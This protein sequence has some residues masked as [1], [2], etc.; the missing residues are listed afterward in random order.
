MMIIEDT[1]VPGTHLTTLPASRADTQ[2]PIPAPESMVVI[3]LQQ[4]PL[5]IR[6][7]IKKPLSK[8]RTRTL[9]NLVWIICFLLLV[10]AGCTVNSVVESEQI[11]TASAM[12]Q[13]ASLIPF[14]PELMGTWVADDPDYIEP[15]G[16][17]DWYRNIE[18][19]YWH[20]GS[21]GI[22][23]GSLV[24][25]VVSAVEYDGETYIV[26][27]YT[28]FNKYAS[29]YFRLQGDKLQVKA[30]GIMFNEPDEYK[31]Y[32]RFIGEWPEE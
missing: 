3:L 4:T 21:L 22:Q 25:G 19:C 6:S 5:T 16:W 18:I 29:Y 27:V 15:S 9:P 26:E 1:V 31:A 2:L 8:S 23:Y 13:Q 30:P 24:G 11:D 32:H 12:A 14:P 17:D 7:E 28:E 10:T 20:D